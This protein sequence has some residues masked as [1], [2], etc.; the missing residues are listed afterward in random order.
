MS[1]T[2]VKKEYRPVAE[3]YQ[4]IYGATVSDATISRWKNLGIMV[5]GKRKTLRTVLL[6]G[7]TC[8]TREWLIE[9]RE[10]QIE[11]MPAIERGPT[12][13]QLE[14]AK[15]SAESFLAAEGI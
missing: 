15:N 6:G 14:R 7:R 12:T 13:K 5:N 9:F 4:D 8:T 10:C 1:F 3:W 2:V 11:P